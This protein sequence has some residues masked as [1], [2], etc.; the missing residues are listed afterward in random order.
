MSDLQNNTEAGMSATSEPTNNP[1]TETKVENVSKPEPS[2]E[3]A[4]VESTMPH[5]ATEQDTIQTVT[6]EHKNESAPVEEKK[7]EAPAAE[8]IVEPI[9][10]G[11]LALKGP[12]LL[13]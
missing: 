8:K 7:D 5:N 4:I 11:Q 1:I 10:E 2:T 6:Q 9:T 3:A 12:G 13:K